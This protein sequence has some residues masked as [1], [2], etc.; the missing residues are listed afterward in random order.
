MT[1][2]PSD[3][4]IPRPL[5]FEL[6]RPHLIHRLS[7]TLH[8]TVVALL[9][10]SGYGKSTLLAQY[11]RSTSRPVIWISCK[12][13]QLDPTSL[14]QSLLEMACNH[15]GAEPSVRFEA[16]QPAT[17]TAR[18]LAST[19]SEL[20]LNCD[21]VFDEV[22]LM[23]EETLSW[24]HAFIN[25][26]GEGHRVLLCAYGPEKLRLARQL[27]D[28]TALVLD[29]RDLAFHPEETASFLLLRGL[30]GTQQQVHHSL[31]GWP[32]GIA[33]YAAGATRHYHP[34]DLVKEAVGK[35]PAPIR[36]HLCEMAV[37]RLWSED[38]VWQLNISLPSDWLEQVLH[39]GLPLT[40]MGNQQYKP[41]QLL[42]EHL[43][44]E[45]Q[46]RPDRLQHLSEQAAVL[47]EKQGETQ[48][49]YHA[50]LQAQ[51]FSEALRLLEG[52]LPQLVQ[53]RDFRRLRELLEKLPDPKRTPAL[54]T[55]LAHSLIQTGAIKQGGQM[56]E[57]QRQMGTLSPEGY[58]HLAS[59]TGRQG[60]PEQQLL[61]AL[62][63]KEHLQEG[64][65]CPPLS[66]QVASA[67]LALGRYQDAEPE[68][69][70]LLEHAEKLGNPQELGQALTMQQYLL[71]AQQRYAEQQKVLVRAVHLFDG[72]G[73]PNQT[74]PLRL[75][76]A[77]ME[78]LSGHFDAAHAHLQ[79]IRRLA[80]E[81]DSVYLPQITEC[82]AT[83]A[84]WAGQPETALN[85]LEEALKQAESIDLKLF[86]AQIQYRMSDV[87]LRQKDLPRFQ[88]TL[89]EAQQLGAAVPLYTHY[90]TFFDAVL[91]LQNQQDQQAHTLLKQVLEQPPER[92]Y[93]T[94]SLALLLETEK[95]LQLDS[96][97]TQHLLD[98]AVQEQGSA[99]VLQLDTQLLQTSKPTTPTVPTAQT[100]PTLNLCT[101]GGFSAQ[102]SG[103][104]VRISLSR[105]IEVLLWLAIHGPST[106]DSIVDALWEGSGEEKNY[107]YFRVAVRRLRSDLQQA[108][109]EVD[110]PVP[111][112]GNVYRLSSQFAVH[113]DL[114]VLQQ[115]TLHPTPEH[116]QDAL[117]LYRG[118]FMPDLDAE[119]INVLREEQ[120][121]KTIHMALQLASLKQQQPLEAMS[122]YKRI[123]KMDPY[124][125][126]A[127]LGV[128]EASHQI[129]GLPAVQQAFE[130]YRTVMEQELFEDLDPN[131]VR[132]VQDIGV[133][134]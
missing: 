16:Q 1:G 30:K 54:T 35:L 84:D 45:L 107:D 111:F 8:M 49:A 25:H 122:V 125:Q 103:Q 28:G 52:L 124:H 17:P 34:S 19:L 105:S 53:Q 113:T 66:W 81:E 109:P 131:V 39:A 119:W 40:P 42:L 18:K 76:L 51:Q 95:R 134:A 21:F 74:I 4:L 91:A 128:L 48:Q 13:D 126:G 87:L 120:R 5:R 27:A 112:E 61:L 68:V 92:Q 108:F 75:M 106:R 60:D 132:W 121:E 85:L 123:L 88:Q 71:F 20:N 56:L 10:P 44:R 46:R 104:G 23:G 116:L 117:D 37:V 101:L 78:G 110:N 90:Q 50:Y 7:E 59:A 77:E 86:C 33:L 64:T 38:L 114:Q 93:H 26:L 11:A 73:L 82:Q 31:E 80:L 6:A 67:L 72:L 12:E 41:H 96:T 94:R 32:A 70:A 69:Q 130:H 62:E 43:T 58:A 99:Q 47:L 3:H 36:Q 102:R 133:K 100:L 24:L 29:T 14:S 115:A 129:G 57:T 97:H 55:L 15:A 83:L 63:G 22:D 2:R 98:R 65:M 79:T 9:A 127:Y 118:D 89:Q